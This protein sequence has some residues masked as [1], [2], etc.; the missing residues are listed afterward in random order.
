MRP[1]HA[2]F[3][4]SGL[5]SLL[6]AAAAQ[7]Q[8]K[9]AAPDKFVLEAGDHELVKVIEA[10]ARFLNRNYLLAP[11][12]MGDPKPTVTLQQRLEL[13]A[14]GCEA[15]VSQ[16]A[17]TRNLVAMP[18]D[19]ARG[20]WEFVNMNG[21]RR[22]EVMAHAIVVTPEVARQMRD[23]RM[24]VS[25]QATVQHVRATMAAQT[26]RPFFATIGGAGLSLG[27]AGNERVILLEGLTEHVAKALD[28]IASIDQPQ[29][30]MKLEDDRLSSL[31][32][33][34]KALEATVQALGAKNKALD[35]KDK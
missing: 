18:L 11:S 27:T 16:L 31:E 13:D 22:A 15:V 6:L 26:L 14:A 8:P 1:L 10:S 9:P 20:L 33:R 23:I 7:D 28:I 24:F 25:T 19:R 17:Y 3:A 29:P 5:L 34:V 35:G 32:N 4:I 21:P 30:L 2:T 12:E